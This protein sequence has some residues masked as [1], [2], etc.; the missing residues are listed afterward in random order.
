MFL[1]YSVISFVLLIIVIVEEEVRT[2]PRI[3]AGIYNLKEN[4]EIKEN[5]MGIEINQLEE[6]K[7]IEAT[8]LEKNSKE[9]NS[10]SLE[11]KSK[12]ALKGF[13]QRYKYNDQVDHHE[14]HKRN[15]YVWIFYSLFTTL[16]LFSHLLLYLE[17]TFWFKLN[18]YFNKLLW[19]GLALDATVVSLDALEGYE[20]DTQVSPEV[21]RRIKEIA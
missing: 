18:S 3:R 15:N 19:S 13:L 2:K 11:M 6:N 14:Q 12:N 9:D 8:N 1:C 7:E 10:N 5:D 20:D 4:E 17:I 16:V 21:E